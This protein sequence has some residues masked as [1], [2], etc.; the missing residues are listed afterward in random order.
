[1][2]RTKT[3]N[4]PPLISPGS[5]VDGFFAQWRSAACHFQFGLSEGVRLVRQNPP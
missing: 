2:I 5:M 3:Q 4:R 1:M